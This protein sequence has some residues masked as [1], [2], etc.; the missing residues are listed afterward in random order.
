MKRLLEC[1]CSRAKITID[2]D[3]VIVLDPA[4]YTKALDIVWKLPAQSQ[5]VVYTYEPVM[6]LPT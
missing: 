1:V 6:W 5:Q 4:I 3:V 2:Y